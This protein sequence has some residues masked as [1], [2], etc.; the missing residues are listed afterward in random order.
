MP[1]QTDA[2]RETAVAIGREVTTMTGRVTDLAEAQFIR[3][4]ERLADSPL[5][6]LPLTPVVRRAARDLP[7]LSGRLAAAAT[8]L[9]LHTTRSLLGTLRRLPDNTRAT[10]DRLD[11]EPRR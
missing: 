7:A 5:P 9:G 10:L 2:T 8:Y 11:R 6:T 1:A 3:T 4:Q